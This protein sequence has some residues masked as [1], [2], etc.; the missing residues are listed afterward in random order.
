MPQQIVSHQAHCRP[1]LAT[2]QPR[3]CVLTANA[4][5]IMLANHKRTKT[6]HAVNIQTTLPRR[7]HHHHRHQRLMAAAINTRPPLRIIITIIISRWLMNAR[8]VSVV[9]AS[10]VRRASENV[11]T[12]AKNVLQKWIISRP[13]LN[14]INCV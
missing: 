1:A 12:P 11:S 9:I 8:C 6:I 10:T 13:N 2:A 4:T 14:W 7:R 5:V 3:P